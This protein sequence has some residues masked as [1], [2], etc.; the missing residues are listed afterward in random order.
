VDA[1]G[2]V[3]DLGMVALS[4]RRGRN[5]GRPG[6]L[7]LAS[8]A[9]G[10]VV[11]VAPQFADEPNHGPFVDDS[12]PTVG[13]IFTPGRDREIAVTLSDENLNDSLF[14]RW[15]IDYPGGEINSRAPLILEAQLPRSG[16][17][18]RSTVRIQP[19]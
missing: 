5:S 4:A 19:K 15:L 14:V 3:G 1:G 13:D 17:S 6:L 12:K 7:L 18:V 8:L 11:P 10:C 2:L 16:A 9:V